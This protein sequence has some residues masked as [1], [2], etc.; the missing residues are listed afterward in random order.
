MKKRFTTKW[1]YIANA[2]FRIVKIMVN[3]VSFLKF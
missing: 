1:P 3:K 2:L